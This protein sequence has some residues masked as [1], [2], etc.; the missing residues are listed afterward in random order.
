HT[1]NAE[2]RLIPS[3]GPVNK[4][5]EPVK[6]DHPLYASSQGSVRNLKEYIDDLDDN[7]A[8]GYGRVAYAQE[9]TAYS[10]PVLTVRASGTEEHD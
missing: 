3:V 5:A 10:E 1:T 7:Y 8:V 2:K 6:P 9:F 4:T